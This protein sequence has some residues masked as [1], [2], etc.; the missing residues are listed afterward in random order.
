MAKTVIDEEYSRFDQTPNTI[1]V[2]NIKSA[3]FEVLKGKDFD[4]FYDVASWRYLYQYKTVFNHWDRDYI[5]EQKLEN[6]SE[7]A[8]LNFETV[9]HTYRLT[10][11]DSAENWWWETYLEILLMMVGFVAERQIAYAIHLRFYVPNPRGNQ[12]KGDAI[13]GN[14]DSVHGRTLNS[15]TSQKDPECI[16]TLSLQVSSAWAVAVCQVAMPRQGRTQIHSEIQAR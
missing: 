9:Y 13:K 10:Q 14:G 4:T 1:A 12:G 3:A 8:L 16:K 2:T 6:G 7:Q 11:Y 15:R 5:N